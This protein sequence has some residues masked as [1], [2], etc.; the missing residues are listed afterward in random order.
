[1]PDFG[2]HD[3]LEAPDVVVMSMDMLNLP[4]ICATEAS[5]YQL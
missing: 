1:V 5:T 2:T 4:G 3:I